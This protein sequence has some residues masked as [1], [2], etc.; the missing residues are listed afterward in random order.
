MFYN[1]SWENY[2]K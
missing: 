2:E 1:R